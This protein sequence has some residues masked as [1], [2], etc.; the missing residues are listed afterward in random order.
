MGV[1]VD[2]A[3][4]DAD[5]VDSLV[6]EPA[7]D[8]NG[9]LRADADLALLVEAH[10]DPDDEVVAD[11]GADRPDHFQRKPDAVL[12]RTAVLVAA[13]IAC[14]RQEFVEKMAAV[15]RDFDAV[16][17]GLLTAQCGV[18]KVSGDPRDVERL[19]GAGK[20][21]VRGLPGTA[22]R[23]RRNPVPGVVIG[24]MAHVGQLGHHRRTLFV[25]VVGQRPQIGH[26]FVTEQ[27]QIAERGGGVGADQRASAHHRQC[28]AT[29]G[30][31]PVIS[32]VTVLRQ[33][34][35]AVGRLVRGTHDP[36]PQREVLDRER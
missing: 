4:D 30:L 16:Q 8:A 31:L 17:T 21:A 3:A 11:R 32:P 15:G 36:V 9:F 5:E 1:G 26:R 28:D 20:G 2:V 6:G 24:A 33:T 35:L 12:E 22:R 10:P 23:D 13:V 19:G 29:A 18:G 7:G 14:G 34:V 25:H 27:L